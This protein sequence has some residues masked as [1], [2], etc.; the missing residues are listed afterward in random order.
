MSDAEIGGIGN[1]PGNQRLVN[2]VH[3]GIFRGRVTQWVRRMKA[4]HRVK[5]QGNVPE[6]FLRPDL[7]HTMLRMVHV[8]D[9][10]AHALDSVANQPLS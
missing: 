6:Y 8:V 2:V 5:K 4:S 10:L 1:S 7:G 9:Y 3:I